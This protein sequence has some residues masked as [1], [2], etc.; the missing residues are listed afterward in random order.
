R[1]AVVAGRGRFRTAEPLFARAP[2]APLARGSIDAGPGELVLADFGAGGA[3]ALRRLGRA[4]RARDVAAALLW[5]GEGRR[6]F[7]SKLVD[8]ARAAA[9]RAREADLAR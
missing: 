8:E 5:E 6:G 1:V 4:G 3:R 7:P 2:E 9:R